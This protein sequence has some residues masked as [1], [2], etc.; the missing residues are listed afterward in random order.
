MN[1]ASFSRTPKDV[2]YHEVTR[3]K[4]L[5]S[6]DSNLPVIVVEFCLSPAQST[7]TK[8]LYLQISVSIHTSS[9]DIWLQAH[10]SFGEGKIKTTQVAI[11][12]CFDCK[13]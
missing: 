9:V 12:Q 10:I 8:Q 6:R 11:D 4:L 13:H 2:E 1:R 7:E 3:L 5:E